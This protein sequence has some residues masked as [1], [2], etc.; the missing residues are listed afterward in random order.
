MMIRT[1]VRPLILPL[2]CCYQM[3]AQTPDAPSNSEPGLTSAVKVMDRPEVR[4]MRVEMK[5]GGYRGVHTHDDVRFHLYIPVSGKVELTIGSGKPV[6]AIPGQAYFMEKG[7]P[8]AFKCIGDS[9]AMV[10]EVF[11]KDTA[12]AA[13]TAVSKEDSQIS[14]LVTAQTKDGQTNSGVKPSV[15]IDRPEVRVLR[16]GIPA[17]VVRAVHTHD[18]VRFHLFIPVAG[19]LE[20]TIGSA[21]PTV[22]KIGQVFYIEKGTLHGF[23]NIGPT[24]GMIME[25]FVKPNTVVA[26]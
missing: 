13:D 14:S 9:P 8:H 6:E 23:R 10:M 1:C 2:L 21:A 24:D 7:T 25:V 20:L 11:V 4:V 17:G 5:P 12:A 19:E 3:A 16:V 26:K 22:A 15:Q 18:D